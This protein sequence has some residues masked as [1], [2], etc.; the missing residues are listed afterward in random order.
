MHEQ[1]LGSEG[2]AQA[3]KFKARR[4]D[5]CWKRDELVDG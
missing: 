4:C 3:E 5:K 2:K 1:V